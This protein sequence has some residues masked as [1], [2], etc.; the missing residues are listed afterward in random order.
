MRGG[1]ARPQHGCAAGP[2]CE[3][4]ARPARPA[5][6]P[7]RRGALRARHWAGASSTPSLRARAAGTCAS[8][9]RRE[10]CEGG[11]SAQRPVQIRPQRP[12][13][14][15]G[16][17]TRTYSASAVTAWAMVEAL[18]KDWRCARSELFD[19]F[20]PFPDLFPADWSFGCC[21]P[22]APTAVTPPGAWLT[23]GIAGGGTGGS[24]APAMPSSAAVAMMS[25]VSAAAAAASVSLQAERGSAI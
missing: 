10:V 5:C 11:A 21:C 2:A 12:Q 23:L 17:P 13:H 8:P 22:G 3:K 19:L 4:A 16:T 15:A 25:S 20:D 1:H 24:P 7:W 6:G 14:I 9:P 18:S